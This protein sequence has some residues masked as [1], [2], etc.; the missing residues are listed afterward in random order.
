MHVSEKLGLIGGVGISFYV[1][2]VMNVLATDSK[3][4]ALFLALRDE[5]IAKASDMAVFTSGEIWTFI[6]ITTGI[7]GWFFARLSGWV[8]KPDKDE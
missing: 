4:I 5:G 8:F 6:A 7:F 3:H 2:F 1:W